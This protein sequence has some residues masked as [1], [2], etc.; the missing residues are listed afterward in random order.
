[1]RVCGWVHMSGS[2]RGIGICVRVCAR[3]LVCERARMFAHVNCMCP[4]ARMIVSKENNDNSK[5]IQIIICRMPTHT[6]ADTDLDIGTH[7]YTDISRYH[8]AASE[9]P[10]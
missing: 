7:T 9:P 1:M 4:C 3:V 6:D 10:R 5:K 2:V 8:K